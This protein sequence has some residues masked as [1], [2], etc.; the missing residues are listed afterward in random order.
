MDRNQLLSR[1]DDQNKVWDVVV[2]GGGATGL[3]CSVDA[4]A[5]GYSVDLF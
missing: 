5:L 3:G 2:I 4:A 1:L